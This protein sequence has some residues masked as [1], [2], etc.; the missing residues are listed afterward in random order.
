MIGSTGNRTSQRGCGF[1]LTVLVA[2]ACPA[3]A[4]PS[5]GEPPRV[6]DQSLKGDLEGKAKFLSSLVGDANLK[7]QAEAVRTD[8]FRNYPEASKTRSDAYLQYMF[9]SFVLS[10]PKL[11]AKEKFQA[12]QEFR[13]PLPAASGSTQ[14]SPN[15]STSGSQSPGV[16]S[17]GDTSISFGAPPAAPSSGAAIPSAPTGPTPSGTVRTEGNQ[18]PGVISRGN[19]GIQYA[20]SPPAAPAQ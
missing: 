19:T 20:P 9:C 4:Q 7:G 8:I 5:C 12:I 1:L 3:H 16:I 6:D 14:G 17:G 2:F 15:V 10:D 13:Q 11:S 18:S